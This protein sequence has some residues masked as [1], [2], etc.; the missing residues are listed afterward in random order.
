ML[1]DWSL[2]RGKYDRILSS[3][4]TILMRLILRRIL[5]SQ[6]TIISRARIIRLM[7]IRCKYYILL[8]ILSALAHS[9]R[10]SILSL[11][12]FHRSVKEYWIFIGFP[13]ITLRII[14]PSPSSSVSRSESIFALIPGIARLISLKF[15]FHSA[16]TLSVCITQRFESV[17]IRPRTGHTIDD[18]VTFE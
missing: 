1:L 13:S 3:Q 10:S 9:F 17:F 18:I 6:E 7:Y 16:I 2:S 14:N 12:D 8:D 5:N 11:R 4:K 15:S